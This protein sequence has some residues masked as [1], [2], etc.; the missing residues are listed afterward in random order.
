MFYRTAVATHGVTLEVGE[1]KHRIIICDVFAD[2][3]FLDFS[4]FGNFENEVGSF[5]VKQV[6][7]KNIPAVFFEKLKMLSGGV[8]CTVIGGVAF[9]DR[10]ADMVNNRLP[11]IGLQIILITPFAR[12]NLDCNPAFKLFSEHFIKLKHLFGCYGF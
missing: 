9:R 10:T 6:N 11:E 5:G 7:R 1:N 12:M 2:I 8:S 3:I 4:A